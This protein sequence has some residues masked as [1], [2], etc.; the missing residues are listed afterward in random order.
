MSILESATFIIKKKL[1][2]FFVGKGDEPEL[3]T[4]VLQFIYVSDNGFRF[5]VVQFPSK[6][7]TPSSLYFCF[8][9]GVLAMLEIGFE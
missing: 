1:F 5:P 8:W 6:D 9:D 3:A 4:H 2:N 7:C